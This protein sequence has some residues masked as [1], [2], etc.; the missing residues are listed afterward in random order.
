MQVV[1][2]KLFQKQSEAVGKCFHITLDNFGSTQNE[3]MRVYCDIL[4]ET[5]VYIYHNQHF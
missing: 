3:K 5:T 4:I 1:K 2:E